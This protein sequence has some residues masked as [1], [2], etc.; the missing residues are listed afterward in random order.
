MSTLEFFI[1]DMAENAR[2][3]T[4]KING[5]LVKTPALVQTGAELTKLTPFEVSQAGTTIVK[6]NGLAWWLKYGEKLS[7]IGDLHRLY[8]WNGLLLVDLQTD[9]AYQLA[10]PRGKKQDGVR[11][12]D[13][14][15]GQL[16]FWQ[17]ETALRVQEILGADILQSFNRADD[18]YAPVDDLAVGVDQT[19]AWLEINRSVA[20]M[21]LGTVV[22][23]GLKK[24][25]KNSIKAVAANNLAGYQISGIPATLSNQEFIRIINEVLTM[26]PSNQPRYLPTSTTLAQLIIAVLAGVDL[27]DSNL[28][29]KKAA[30]GIA[31]VGEN[32]ESLHLGRQHFSFDKQPIEPG[33]DCPVCQSGYSRA[34]IHSLIIDGK[35]WGEQLLL[36]HNLFA[37]N[38]MMTNFRQAI[39]S[40]QIK[41]FIQELL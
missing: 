11:F 32:L 19:Q 25:R 7:E 12:H 30:K 24:L 27:I 14:K 15:T 9:Y 4:L 41:S 18:Y 36:R 26:L 29:A 22:G 2:T 39:A 35:F 10:K 40:Q 23:G 8:Q 13:P 37:L 38:K 28:A 3:G 33:C 17:P 6:I 20:G 16:K 34:L 5:H 31:L 1:N 21:T